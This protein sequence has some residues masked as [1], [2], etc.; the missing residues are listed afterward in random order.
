VVVVLVVVVLVVLVLAVV[1][2]VQKIQHRPASNLTAA[3]PEPGLPSPPPQQDSD[4]TWTKMASQS[5]PVQAALLSP[6]LPPPIYEPVLAAPDAPSA[7][8][9]FCYLA[10]RAEQHAQQEK[11]RSPASPPPK[12]AASEVEE[13]AAAMAATKAQVATELLAP[14]QS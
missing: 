11:R 10:K 6:R 12:A 13:P 2:A 14:C 5:T 3:D 9:H 4:Q 7:A 8:D 1:M